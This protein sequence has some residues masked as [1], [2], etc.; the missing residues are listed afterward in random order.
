MLVYLLQSTCYGFQMLVRA[1]QAF[2]SST[3]LLAVR[4]VFLLLHFCDV[5]FYFPSFSVSR[6]DMEN[7][8]FYS[9]IEHK[10]V[11]RNR[12]KKIAEENKYKKDNNWNWNADSDM[13]V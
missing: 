13:Y 10:F 2:K 11:Q 12:E 9:H 5:S 6:N 1:Q 8:A 3:V 7:I 4:C